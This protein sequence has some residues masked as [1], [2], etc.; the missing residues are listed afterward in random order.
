MP[1][2][3]L[4]GACGLKGDLYIPEKESGPAS[5]VVESTDENETESQSEE[6]Q[7]PD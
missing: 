2:L 4:T 1:T 5:P 7:I 6:E 3:L